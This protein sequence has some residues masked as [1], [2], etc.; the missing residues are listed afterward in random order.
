MLSL[1]CVCDVTKDL[2]KMFINH[3]DGCLI[4][5]LVDRLVS[6]LVCKNNIIN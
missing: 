1:L 2:N 3:H 5:Y 4:L 6:L